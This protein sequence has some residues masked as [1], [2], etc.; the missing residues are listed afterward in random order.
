MFFF[1][2]FAPMESLI[3][4][5]YLCNQSQST[6]VKLGLG[7]CFR[8]P[9]M[10]FWARHT[11]RTTSKCYRLRVKAMTPDVTDHMCAV[12]Q[13]EKTI[14][15]R[16]EW[17]IHG[18]FETLWQAQKSLQRCRAA[19]SPSNHP[20]LGLAFGLAGHQREAIILFIFNHWRL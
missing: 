3:Y 2:L 11:A 1:R 19:Q 12:L 16:A 13:L 15:M 18:C 10:S 17:P 9:K 4:E 8:M 6:V 14:Q 5:N 7:V 20:T